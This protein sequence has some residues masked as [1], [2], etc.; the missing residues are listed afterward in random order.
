[1]PPESRGRLYVKIAETGPQ[2]AARFRWLAAQGFP[3]PEVLDAGEH[4]GT[5]WLVTTALP[6][7]S[8]AEPWPAVQRD[9]VIDAVAEAALAL[10]A[11]PV[12]GCPFG[13][14][15]GLV[16]PV[17]AHGDFC[18]PNVLLDPA[19]LRLAGVVDVG[20]LGVAERARDLT[21]AATS[22]GSDLNPQYGPAHVERFQRRYGAGLGYLP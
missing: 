1:M 20:A 10:H 5:G 9:G 15:A 16:D 2:E 17:V 3:V 13:D 18:L 4:D 19:T 22:I 14:R 21:D 7:R 11:L 12:A 6:G 8:A